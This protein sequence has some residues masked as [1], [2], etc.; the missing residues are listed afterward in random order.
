MTQEEIHLLIFNKAYEKMLVGHF[1][2]LP[3]IVKDYKEKRE[4]FFKKEDDT[5]L[6]EALSTAYHN[7]IINLYSEMLNIVYK[8]E[9]GDIFD[10]LT[11]YNNTED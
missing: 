6:A 1:M 8:N 4:L 2:N 5:D 10:R 3:E 11:D 7:K 9:Y